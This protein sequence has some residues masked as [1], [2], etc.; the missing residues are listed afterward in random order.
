MAKY[1]FIKQTNIKGEVI[2]YT[3]KDGVYVSDSVCLDKEKA[4]S[5]YNNILKYGGEKI[6]EVLAIH[7]SEPF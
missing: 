6:I 1:E 7:K 5:I 2:Y 3:T 4:L